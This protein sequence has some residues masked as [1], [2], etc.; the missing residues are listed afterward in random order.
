MD[1]QSCLWHHQ[2]EQLA[3]GLLVENE[4]ASS[5][6]PSDQYVG[7]LQWDQNQDKLK[8]FLWQGAPLILVSYLGAFLSISILG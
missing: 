8:P 7:N 6:Q 2:Q 1:L 4:V 3:D 5:P